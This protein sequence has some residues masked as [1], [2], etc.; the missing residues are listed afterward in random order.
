MSDSTTVTSPLREYFT[1]RRAERVVRAYTREQHSLVRECFAAADRRRV[2]GRRLVHTVP[3]CVLLRDSV[4][5]YWRGV[6]AAQATRPAGEAGDDAAEGLPALAPAPLRPGASPSDDARVRAAL[7]SRDPLYFDALSDED[8]AR[9]RSALDRAAS[10]VRALVEVRTLPNLRGTRWGRRLGVAVVAAYAA[11]VGLRA[12]LLPPNV[13]LHK[14]V[15]ASSIWYAPGADQTIVDGDTGTSFGVHTRLEDGANVVIDLL[16]TYRIY[17]IDVHNRVDGWFDDGLP[18]VVELSADGKQF[19]EIARRETH[20][21]GYPP[22][23][24]DGRREAA[25]FVR[26]RVAK[27]AYLALSEVEVFGKKK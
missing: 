15:I 25:R 22:W 14:P 8:A 26:V 3:A 13:A 5:L 18:L 20:F 1:L 11:V 7:A 6:R 17:R 23:T 21:D 27:R 2:A 24:V 12:I 9:A 16:D 10:M 4:L 19:H